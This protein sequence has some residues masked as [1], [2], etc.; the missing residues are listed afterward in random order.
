MLT[1]HRMAH[2]CQHS[3]ATP[4]CLG[5]PH[6]SV[7]EAHGAATEVFGGMLER[8][9]QVDRIKGVLAMLQRYESLFRLP[10]RIRSSPDDQ[11]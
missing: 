7:A 4:H 3:Y 2:H 8:Q 11:L 1:R 6:Q 9:A 5:P 10:T